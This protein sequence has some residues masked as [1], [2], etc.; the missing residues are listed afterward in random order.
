MC[1]GYVSQFIEDKHYTFKDFQAG[2]KRL[3][4]GHSKG[5][6]NIN[7]EGRPGELEG[8]RV[9]LEDVQSSEA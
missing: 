1:K 9:L 8:N 4:F 2:C 7:A 3:A 5:F 6:F